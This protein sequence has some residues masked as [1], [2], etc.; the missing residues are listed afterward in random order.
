MSKR[1]DELET[2]PHDLDACAWRPGVR[3]DAKT[4]A[5]SVAE[6]FRRNGGGADTSEP[7]DATVLPPGQ[8]PE[9]IP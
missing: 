8:A 1:S 9:V 7:M 2:V 5:N 3:T 4:F 6:F